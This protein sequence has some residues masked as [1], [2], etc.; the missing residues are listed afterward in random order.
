[1]QRHA[2]PINNK[3]LTPGVIVLIVLTLLGLGTLALRFLFGLG[4]VTNLDDNYPWGIWIAVDV[5]SG[6]A[7]AA[8]GFTT[9]FLAEILHKKH[10]HAILRP[11]LLTA[12]L[13]YTFVALGVFTDIGR[14]YNIWHALIPYCWN[15]NSVMFEVGTCVVLYLNVLYIEF[16]PI[17]IERFYNKVNLPGVLSKLNSLLNSILGLIDKT[18]GKFIFLFVIAGVVLSCLH[19]SSL[20]TL[21]LIAPYKVHPSVVYSLVPFVFPAFSNNGWISNGNCR[22]FVGIK[23]I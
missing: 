19:Q 15:G 23:I 10:F 21:M 1:M 18:L 11:A 3:F 13:G 12:L 22:I 20:G 4:Y 5:A 8:G 17:I 9:A 14:Y 2:L 16:V 7:L 6:V